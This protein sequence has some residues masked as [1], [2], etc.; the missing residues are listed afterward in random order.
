MSLLSSAEGLKTGSLVKV[1]VQKKVGD[2]YVCETSFGM[3]AIITE[4]HTGGKCHTPSARQ[5]VSQ[6]LI[7]PL[8][9][10]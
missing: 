8:P 10:P 3:P 6:R 5:T 2:G 1:K 4:L 9:I 7:S